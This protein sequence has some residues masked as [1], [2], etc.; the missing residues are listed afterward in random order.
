VPECI[1]QAHPLDDAIRERD[2]VPKLLFVV[3][4]RSGI[5]CT[6]IFVPDDGVE[7]EVLTH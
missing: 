3:H 4:R 2:I 5:I 7:R 1:R 6:A